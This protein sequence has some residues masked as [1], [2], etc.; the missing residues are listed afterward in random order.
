MAPCRDA[1]IRSPRSS[2]AGRPP[3]PTDPFAAS[4][5]AGVGLVRQRRL[6]GHPRREACRWPL[7]RDSPGER[8]SRAVVADGRL[9]GT[10][11]ASGRAARSKQVAGSKR[12]PGG[13]SQRPLTRDS[14]GE[15]QGRA[16]G[17]RRVEAGLTRRAPGPRGRSR[18]RRARGALGP[19]PPPSGSAPEGTVRMGA[20]E[21]AALGESLQAV[22]PD[23]H[24]RGPAVQ[25]PFG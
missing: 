22:R 10:H 9:R 8:Q 17:A 7:T 25:D 12:R 24:R 3:Q 5:F 4:S 14:P 2:T 21:V 19:A 1:R 11:L 13:R 18:W 16:V 6:A 20:F 15:R 23:V